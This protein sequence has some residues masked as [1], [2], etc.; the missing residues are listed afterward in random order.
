MQILICKTNQK[1]QVV[2]NKQIIF[3]FRA[4]LFTFIHRGITDTD[5]S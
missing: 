3:T 2:M 4:Y 5:V 1:Q